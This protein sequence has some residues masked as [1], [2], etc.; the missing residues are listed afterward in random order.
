[1]V[2]KG[3]KVRQQTDLNLRV[4]GQALRSKASDQNIA[5]NLISAITSRLHGQQQ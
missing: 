5:K 4:I 3:Q 2:M 1:M